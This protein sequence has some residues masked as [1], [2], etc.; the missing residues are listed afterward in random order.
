MEYRKRKRNRKG[1]EV[2][3]PLGRTISASAF[4]GTPLRAYVGQSSTGIS[5]VWTGNGLMI[6]SSRVQPVSSY[7]L[8][9]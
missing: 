5:R 9:L 1:G 8:D 4:V 6:G 7:N 2:Q 3:A